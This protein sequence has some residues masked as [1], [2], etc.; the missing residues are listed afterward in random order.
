MGE[1]G[2]RA[3]PPGPVVDV[4]VVERFGEEPG[5]LGDLVAVLGQVGLPVRAGRRGQGRRLAEHV[6]RA[7]HGEPRSERVPEPAVVAAVPACDEVGRLAQAALEDPV[8]SQ[9]AS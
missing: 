6:G 8:G 5:D 2:P 4:D 3:E 9:A 1:D 7:R